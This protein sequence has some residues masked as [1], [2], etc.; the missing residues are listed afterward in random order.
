MKFDIAVIGGGQ[1]GVCAAIAAAQEGKK[2]V[3]LNDR[4]L[5]GG[6]ASSECFVPNHGAEA[7]SH[8]RNCREGGIL[9]DMRLDYYHTFSPYSDNR[10]YWNLILWEYCKKEKNLTVLLHTRAY[11]LIKE[12]RRVTKIKA[13][14]LETEEQYEIEAD[15]F[16]DD[17]GDGWA[18]FNAGASYRFG[19]EAKAE[20]GEQV[21][22]K[23]KADSRTLGCSIYGFAVKRDYPVKFKKPEWAKTYNQCASLPNRPHDVHH[24]FP[25]IAASRDQRNIQ[26]F[27]WLEW[28]GHLNVIKDIDKIYNHLL[29]ELFGLWDHLKNSCTS[30]TVKALENFELT[31]WSAFPMKRESRRIEG[32]YILNEN[33]LFYPKLFEDRIGFGGWPLD[34]HPPEGV[35][36]VDPPCDQVFFI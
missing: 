10:A 34:D 28:G 26:F 30:E 23:E 20:F 33:D 14:D 25:T 3:I 22:G 16:I 21:F 1:P 8:N 7:M 5:L 13:I 31:S 12:A 11:E 24:I 17:T 19:R 18:A 29:K 9:E 6:N 2:V 15:F 32:D 4:P 35:E 27:W 36:S